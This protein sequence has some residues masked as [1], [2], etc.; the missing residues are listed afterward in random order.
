MKGQLTALHVVGPLAWGGAEQQVCELVLSSRSADVRHVICTLGV[1]P[2][3]RAPGVVAAGVEIAPLPVSVKN[4]VRD[5]GRLAAVAS[6]CGADLLHAHTATNAIWA[7]LAAR[8]MGRPVVFSEYGFNSAR[9]LK[10]RLFERSRTRA[11]EHVTANSEA[12]R[13]E[14][15]QRTQIPPERTETIHSGL[16]PTRFTPG[17][18]RDAVRDRLE[19]DT[20]TAVILNVA[21]V[22]PVKGQRFLVEAAARVLRSRPDTTFL[23]ARHESSP[24]EAS[25]AERA[26]E[27]G[28]ER[29][30]RFLNPDD[31]DVS[32][33]DL[34]AA[35]DL[36]V[37]PSLSE[38]LPI[39]ALEAM[40]MALPVVATDVGGVK[41]VVADGETGMLVPPGDVPRLARAIIELGSPA[42]RATMGAAGRRRFETE[43]TSAT[44]VARVEQMYRNLVTDAG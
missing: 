41:E 17:A 13:Q 43:F 37:L 10:H 18:R 44:M 34:M 30:F 7:L 42:K 31:L 28:I 3:P 26:R 15:L 21:R 16:E 11:A 4:I 33:T 25:L 9:T 29:R 39:T 2:G 8:K 23:L 12:L 1:D 36:F 14:I 40:A 24:L 35:S 32:V 38:S 22:H 20:D 5:T 27:F 19:V 6:A